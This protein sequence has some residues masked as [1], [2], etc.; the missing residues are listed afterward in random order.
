MP[1][2]P[3]DDESMSLTVTLAGRP[4][5]LRVV[6]SDEEPIRRIAKELNDKVVDFQKGYPGK[7]K[8]DCLAMLLLIYAVDLHKAKD[9]APPAGGDDPRIAQTLQRLERDITAALA[10]PLDADAGTAAQR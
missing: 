6:P 4:Y 7:D 3:S 1:N 10:P 8:Q 9:G 5:P 2:P